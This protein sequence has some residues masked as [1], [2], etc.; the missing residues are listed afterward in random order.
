MT[1][2]SHYLDS[3]K[4]GRL[5]SL[6]RPDE[7]EKIVLEDP[8]SAESILVSGSKTLFRGAGGLLSTA[9]DYVRFQQMMLNGGELEGARIL[10]RKTVELMLA[11]HTGDLEIGLSG[12]GVGFGLGYAVLLD[13]G[14]AGTPQTEGSAWWGG[15]YGT[16]FWVDPEEELIGVLMIQVRPNRHLGIRSEFRNLVYQ[17]IVD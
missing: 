12:D 14:L 11:N 15:A 5:A 8:G 3:S 6:Y 13:R 1:D 7:A 17:A 10:G 9:T 4:A 16:S 2:T